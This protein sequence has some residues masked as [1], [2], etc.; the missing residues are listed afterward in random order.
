MSHGEVG[1]ET[2]AGLEVFLR[3]E[4]GLRV[5]AE[6]DARA[7][8]D[9]SW[10]LLVLRASLGNL[11]GGMTGVEEVCLVSLATKLVPVYEGRISSLTY[12]DFDAVCLLPV[13]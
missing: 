3:G 13:C 10:N 5:R 11:G 8:V 4:E 6:L 1:L 2:S 9:D 7:P 12:V